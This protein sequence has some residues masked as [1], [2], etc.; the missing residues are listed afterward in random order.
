[1]R[2]YLRS[3]SR[4]ICLELSEAVLL[5][6]LPFYPERLREGQ[7]GPAACGFERF[8]TPGLSLRRAFPQSP[9]LSLR[10][11]SC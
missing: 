2:V 10:L 11:A 8:H 1:M 5:Q 6:R 9:R 4:G 3:R 7:A